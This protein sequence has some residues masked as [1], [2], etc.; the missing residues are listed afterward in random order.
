MSARQARQ[1]A[2][3]EQQLAA[4]ARMRATSWFNTAAACFNLTRYMEARQYA[5]LV[6]DD[7]QFGDRARDLLSRLPVPSP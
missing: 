1:I 7:P 2:R 4:Q 6:L 5:V 3:R